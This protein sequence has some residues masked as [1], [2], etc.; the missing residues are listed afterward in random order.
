MRNH[1]SKFAFVYLWLAYTLWIVI[2]AILQRGTLTP[3]NWC[4]TPL[5]F[6]FGIYKLSEAKM[7]LDLQRLREIDRE[8]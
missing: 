8:P 2:N 5:C 6:L 3:L 7:D 1:F 4:A